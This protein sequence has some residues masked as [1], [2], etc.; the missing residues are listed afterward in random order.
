MGK[1]MHPGLEKSACEFGDGK[2]FFLL[3]AGCGKENCTW[4]MVFTEVPKSSSPKQKQTEKEAAR[5]IC[6]SFSEQV[7][8]QVFHIFPICSP[9]FPR[10]SHWK[11]H[12]FPCEERL[13]PGIPHGLFSGHRVRSSAKD[14]S[15]C[16]WTSC[17]TNGR[18]QPQFLSSFG[19]SPLWWSH[20][21]PAI[22]GSSRILLAF[23]AM[24]WHRC[25][26]YCDPFPMKLGLWL[27]WSAIRLNHNCGDQGM[28]CTGCFCAGTGVPLWFFWA[29]HNRVDTTSML[30][31]PSYSQVYLA[32]TVDRIT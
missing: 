26:T 4:S 13:P 29:W 20:Y 25:D 9:H 1:K 10:I 22:S 12:I 6:R 32:E 18:S 5:T 3:I 15:A 24:E 31:I 17:T 21:G 19:G 16:G 30:H 14:I 28:P 7:S 27:G 11:L 8:P 2:R 23:L